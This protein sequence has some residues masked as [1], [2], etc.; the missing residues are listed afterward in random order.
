MAEFVKLPEKLVMSRKQEESDSHTMSGTKLR[1]HVSFSKLLKDPYLDVIMT[2]KND[3]RVFRIF[4]N[5]IPKPLKLDLEI[6]CPARNTV[7]QM[8]PIINKSDKDWKFRVNLQSD[9]P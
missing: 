5:I 8:V 7:S 1:M 4:L 6:K 2:H 3:I 9:S